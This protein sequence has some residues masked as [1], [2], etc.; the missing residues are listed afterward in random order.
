MLTRT[1]FVVYRCLSQ[2]ILR[3]LKGYFGGTD[4]LEPCTTQLFTGKINMLYTF[5]GILLPF[6]MQFFF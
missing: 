5:W 4:Y 6:E 2:A 1:Y 3:Y